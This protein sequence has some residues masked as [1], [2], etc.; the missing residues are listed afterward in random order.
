M[1][2][3]TTIT[4]LFKMGADNGAT[5]QAE[6]RFNGDV[7]V[8]M[9]P[10]TRRCTKKDGRG[11]QC[12]N[13]VPLDAKY[14]RCDH[15][16]GIGKKS[17]QKRRVAFRADPAAQAAAANQVVVP[18]G[19]VRCNNHANTPHWCRRTFSSKSKFKLCDE[20]RASG[21]KSD[22]KRRTDPEVR[23]HEAEYS[24]EYRQ[25]PA[26]RASQK[27]TKK[28]PVSKLRACLYTTLR[29]AGAQSR[30]LKD[31]GTFSSDEDV[32]KHFESTFENWMTWDNHGVLRHTHD[33]E[34]VWHIGHR[35]PCAVYN[36]DDLSDARKCFDR[37]NLYAQDAREN[38]EFQD[39]LVL[40]DAELLKL[41]PIW[42]NKALIKGLEWFKFRCGLENETSRE[43]LA[44]KLQKE[45][46]RA[47]NLGLP[48]REEEEDDYDEDA[49]MP[50]DNEL[51]D[52]EVEEESEEEEE[53][54]DE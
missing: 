44:V 33:Y 42:P 39:R 47:K 4:N 20:C 19:H 40:T 21:K 22:K 35:I 11:V 30:T 27:R 12:K 34:Q 32:T 31:L 52:D 25:T 2:T 17:D 41:K 13:R 46:V 49:C 3:Q 36:L 5:M 51:F 48:A 29:E 53:E 37:R 54:E 9:Q 38:I 7:K 43:I 10:Q 50:D 14:K 15:C 6:F 26:G 16:R 1:S 24:R 28:K 23:A 8:E 45:R 18:P